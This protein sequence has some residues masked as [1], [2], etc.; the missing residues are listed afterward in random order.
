METNHNGTSPQAKKDSSDPQNY[1][2]I[3]LTSCLCKT[4]ER[5]INRLTKYLELNNLKSNLQCRF[6][7]KRGTVDHLIRLESNIREAFIKNEHFTAI[8]FDL[9]KAYDTTWK[10]GVMKDL[11][12]LGIKG[13]FIEGFLSNRKFRVCVDT[14]FSSVKNQEEGVPQGSTLS[15]TLFNIN[16]NNI[17][18]ELPPEIDGSLYVDDLMLQ[19]KI[20]TH[21]RTEIATRTKENQ[22]MG[23]SKWFQVL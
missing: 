9:E 21:N 23:N 5:I 22:Q 18:K 8:F 17:T 7:S 11:H 19:I 2:P 1:R 15:L 20:Y 14:T 13:R 3:S 16:I 4:M 6:H 10:Y 12:E